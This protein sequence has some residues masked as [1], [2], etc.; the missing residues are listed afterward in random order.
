VQL[1]RIHLPLLW[2]IVVVG[3]LGAGAGLAVARL[4]RL[5][6]APVPV[7]V[8]LAALLTLPADGIL[9][10]QSETVPGIPGTQVADWARAQPGFEDGRT[11]RFAGSVFGQL[12]GERLQNRLEL[13]PA[14]TPCAEVRLLTERGLLV[15]ADEDVFAR[16][17]VPT[18]ASCLAGLP[19]RHE[20]PNVRV[21]GDLR[22]RSR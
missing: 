20:L 13:V 14:D 17:G 4:P 2:T 15:V 8:G 11:I 22:A 3:I 7:A 12:A 9:R 16:L 21:Y 10:R 18:P 19:P 5:G 1:G 6:W